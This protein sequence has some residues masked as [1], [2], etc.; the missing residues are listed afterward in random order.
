VGFDLVGKSTDAD[1]VL[2][3]LE[4]VRQAGSRH[5]AEGDFAVGLGGV[6]HGRRHVQQ[7][8][9]AQVGF[10][11]VAFGVQAVRLGE[12]L[13]VNVAGGIAGVVEPVFGEFNGK[14][15]NGDLCKPVIKPSTI[16]RARNSMLPNSRT[17]FKSKVG[18]AKGGL[19]VMYCYITNKP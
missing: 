6:V 5:D 16:W 12:Y 10:F 7:Y 18:V 4:Q 2:L 14:P 17:C 1:G 15:W 19:F 8:L 3:L 13:P 9:A 11:L